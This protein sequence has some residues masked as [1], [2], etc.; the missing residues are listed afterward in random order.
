MNF[1]ELETGSVFTM[2]GNPYPYRKTKPVGLLQQTGKYTVNAI[3]EKGYFVFVGDGETVAI[4]T[5]EI[6]KGLK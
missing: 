2:C 6:P 5:G 3:S 1:G 4:W